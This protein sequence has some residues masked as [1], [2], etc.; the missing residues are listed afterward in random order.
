MILQAWVHAWPA[1]KLVLRLQRRERLARRVEKL[2]GSQLQ[3]SDRAKTQHSGTAV[4][5]T[6]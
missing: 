2:S 3:L 6:R 4:P 1:A 5:L